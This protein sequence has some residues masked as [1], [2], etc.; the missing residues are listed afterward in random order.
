[1]ITLLAKL[2]KV[3]NSDDS[4]AQ[5]AFAVLLA[6]VMGITPLY[7]VHNL[8][9][10]FLVLVIRV[11]LTMFLVSFGLFTLIAYLLDPLSQQ[12]G[13][14]LLQSDGLQGLWTSLYQSSVWRLLAFNNTLVLGSLTLCLLLSPVLFIGTQI[15][16][17]QYRNRL[18]IW[19]QKTRLGLML[20]GGRLFSAYESLK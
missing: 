14:L 4:P 2:L 16:V 19:V 5:I 10:L 7:S 6:A 15:L 13:Q 18:I 17:K 3:L 12:L 11:N 8:F 1:M 20:K 9:I